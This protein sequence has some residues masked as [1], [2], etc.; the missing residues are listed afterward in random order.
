MKINVLKVKFTRAGDS[1]V[2]LIIPVY[3]ASVSVQILEELLSEFSDNE[4][5]FRFSVVTAEL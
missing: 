1:E 2:E 3:G 4:S 5:D